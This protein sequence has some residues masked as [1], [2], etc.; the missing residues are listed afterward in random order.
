MARRDDPDRLKR[1][2]ALERKAK[3]RHALRWTGYVMFAL[4]I[5]GGAGWVVANAPEGPQR[6]HWHAYYQVWIDDEEV[7]FAN[8]E[9][10]GMKYGAAHLHAP[11]YNK[12][13]NEAEEGKGTLG[14]FF[15]F[16]LGGDF[17]DHEIVL[18]EGT[19]RPGTYAENETQELRLFVDNALEGKEWIEVEGGF[20]DISFRD[21]DR[22]LIL[23]GNHTDDEIRDLQARYPSFVKDDSPE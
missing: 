3:V 12:I 10:N 16:T 11:A 20:A 13:H 6:V 4:V 8:P 2:A 14:R 1:V 17:Q 19:S 18:P 22:Y 21:G 7:S 15:K 9:F 5:I 23:Y